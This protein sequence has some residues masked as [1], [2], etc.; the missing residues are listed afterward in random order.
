MLF[1]RLFPPSRRSDWL[2]AL[3]INAASIVAHALLVSIVLSPRSVER[4]TEIP[5]SLKW[6]EFLL[7]PDRPK[8]SS[9]VRE[10]VIHFELAAPGGPGALPV[11]QLPESDRLSIEKPLGTAQATIADEPAPP[12][13]SQEV[14]QDTILTILDV[15]TAATRYDDSAAPPYPASMLS[16]KLEGTVA[17]QYVVDT[18]GTADPSSFMVLSTTHPDFS[19]SVQTALPLMR[20]RPA[21]IGTHKVRQLVQQMFSFRIDSATTAQ[22]KTP[23]R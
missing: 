18:T 13:Q 2:A 12:P 11:A 9:P 16:R 6:A 17:V 3:E 4:P 19:K 1:R 15:D 10:Q 8:G 23:D 20:F 22:R 21:V 7:P 14:P 5:E